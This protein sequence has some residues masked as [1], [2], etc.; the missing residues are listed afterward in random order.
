MTIGLIKK[1]C[2]SQLVYDVSWRCTWFMTKE[3]TTVAH[4]SLAC[5]IWNYLN[6][7]NTPHITVFSLHGQKQRGSFPC[8]NTKFRKAQKPPGTPRPSRLWLDFVQIVPRQPTPRVRSP[9]TSLRS[10][11]GTAGNDKANTSNRLQTAV[12]KKWRDRSKHYQCLQE[13]N[14]CLKNTNMYRTKYVTTNT[15]TNQS[16]NKT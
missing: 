16:T 10:S 2:F 9:N 14:K 6:P 1:W 8:L 4:D 12:N 7:Q 15:Q 5:S 3:H 11:K 13:T